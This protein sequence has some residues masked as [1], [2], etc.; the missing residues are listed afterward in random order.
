M[1]DRR[2]ISSMNNTSFASKE[3]SKPARSPGLSN[4]GPEVTLNPT[5]SSLAMI[6]DRVVFPNPGGPCKR[7]WSRDSPL[8]LAAETKIWRFS[9]TLSCPLKSSKSNGRSATSK[10]RSVSLILFLCISKFS[11]I[12]ILAK[13]DEYLLN[14][15]SYIVKTLYRF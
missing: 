4:T 15:D 13:I 10:S 12:S 3:V 11:S 5:P 14:F 6:L 9:T 1:G 2:C 8:I 7:V